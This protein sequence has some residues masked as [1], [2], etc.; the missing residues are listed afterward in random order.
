[1]TPQLPGVTTYTSPDLNPLIVGDHDFF[2]RGVTIA[3]GQTLVAGTVLGKITATSKYVKSLQA[4]NDG[5]EAPDGVLLVDVDAS[6][7]DKTN[8]PVLFAGA[9]D[10]TKLTLGA[11]H[12]LASIWRALARMGLFLYPSYP[13]G[14]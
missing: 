5:S 13:T 4:S 1:M 12:T 9:V 7:G 11:G 2:S 6:G 10:Q 3:S 8:I 14:A